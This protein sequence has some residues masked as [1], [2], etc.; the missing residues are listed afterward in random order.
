MV[1]KAIDIENIKKISFGNLS[2]NR[3]TTSMTDRCHRSCDEVLYES[4]MTR[5]RRCHV[6]VMKRDDT[7]PW[8]R[9]RDL[10]EIRQG[11]AKEDRINGSLERKWRGI[12]YCSCK[13]RARNSPSVINRSGS[14]GPHAHLYHLRGIQSP[15]CTSS[16]PP[17][18]NES[19][20]RRDRYIVVCPN[21]IVDLFL[22]CRGRIF[23]VSI[24]CK[25]ARN[26]RYGLPR[27]IRS[28][29]PPLTCHESSF[30]TI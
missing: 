29:F 14:N 22:I 23:V 24:Y 25:R 6:H 5:R 18:V 28:R 1:K 4:G 10:E 2:A 9:R 8:T 3:F 17:H 27:E 7:G 20:D 26:E 16:S 11:R 13:R 30:T 15:P 21:R 19:R 12:N